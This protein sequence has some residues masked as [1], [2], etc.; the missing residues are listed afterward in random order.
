MSI[1]IQTVPPGTDAKVTTTTV[2]DWVEN[3]TVWRYWSKRCNNDRGFWFSRRSSYTTIHAISWLL[4]NNLIFA[5]PLSTKDRVHF[6]RN[7][8]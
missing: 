7:W 5:G 4:D 2:P 3:S 1:N 6:F 8:S